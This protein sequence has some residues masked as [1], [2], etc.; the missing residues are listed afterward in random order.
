[1]FDNYHKW[2][3]EN[4]VINMIKGDYSAIDDMTPT[5]FPHG[6]Y[7]VTKEGVPVYI[8]RYAKI[9][10]PQMIEVPYSMPIAKFQQLFFRI[11]LRKN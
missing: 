4:N 10:I 1:M 6:Y 3:L 5:I 8:E 11:S 7:G 9:D 2:A